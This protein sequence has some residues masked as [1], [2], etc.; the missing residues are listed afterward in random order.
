MVRTK[1]EALA[2]VRAHQADDDE[3]VAEQLLIVIES[4]VSEVATWLRSADAG[5][6]YGSESWALRRRIADALERGTYKSWRS[7][8]DSR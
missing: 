7:R 8:V 5:A 4:E 2:W 6:L 1:D 3:Q